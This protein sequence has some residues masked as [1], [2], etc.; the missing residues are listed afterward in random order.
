MAKSKYDKYILNEFK[1]A[2]FPKRITQKQ[3]IT[4]SEAVVEKLGFNFNFN[5]VA[6]LA[7]HMLGDPPHDHNCDELL[8]FIPTDMKNYPDLG[9]EAEIAL[10]PEWEKHTITTAAVI[11]LP[12]GINHAP[13]YMKKV[14]KPFYFGHMLLAGKYASSQTPEGSGAPTP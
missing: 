7:P 3:G 8:F 2:D 1:A 11:V 12:P 4:L 14:T 9:G 5:F 10:G 6:V 13:I